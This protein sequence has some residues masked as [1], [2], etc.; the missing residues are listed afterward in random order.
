MLY[1]HDGF[2]LGNIRRMLGICTH[3]LD[4]ID[5][6]S[7]LVVSGS[8][9]LH[10]FRLQKRLD[11]IKLPCLNRGTSGEISVKYLGIGIDQTIKLRS[12]LILSAI[13][14]F[15]P[16]VFLVDKK[17]YGIRNE[18]KSTIEYLTTK[19][20]QTPLILILR[21][22]LDRPE[23]IIPEWQKHGYY[24]AIEKYYDRVL[25]VGTPEIFDIREQYQLPPMVAKK[26]QFCGY[27]RQQLGSKSPNLVRSE[28][29]LSQEEQLILVTPGGG[30]DGYSLIDTYLSSLAL[31]PTRY[32]LRSLII[33]GPEMPLEQQATLQQKAAAYSHVEIGEFTNDLMSYI[34]AADAVV[35]MG[36]YNTICEILS[37]NK[38]AVIVPR[39][40][41]SQEQYIRAKYLAKLG[42]LTAIHPNDLTPD[43]LLRSLL[44]QLHIPKI[45][46]PEINLNGLPKISQYI[47]NLLAKKNNLIPFC[48]Q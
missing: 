11:Y 3:L 39:I 20:P 43:I 34:A 22:I 37:V 8:P 10:S 40:K 45:S 25:V 23:A 46:I 31:L 14:N 29:K 32:K 15:K 30:E 5:R 48:Y 27:I 19:L 33:C 17:P 24:E 35:A 16:D 4:S 13:A 38:P 42:V 36:G 47:S 26:V 18:L 28:L 12:E 41:P 7:I 2:G 6:L 21:D 44:Q 9:M 1:S